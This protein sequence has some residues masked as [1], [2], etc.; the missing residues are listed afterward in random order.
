MIH[1]QLPASTYQ[2]FEAHDLPDA[3][4]I[5]LNRAL[6]DGT[7]DS[8]LQ[9]AACMIPDADPRPPR[10][11]SRTIVLEAERYGGAAIGVHGG[12]V[13]CGNRAGLSIKGIGCNPLVGSGAPED[14]AHGGLALSEGLREALWGEVFTIA[15]P[16]GAV[17][18]LGVIS[19]GSLCWWVEKR[20]GREALQDRYG[21]DV[22]I[23]RGLIARETAIRPAHFERAMFHCPLDPTAYGPT[24]DVTR[25]RDAAGALRDLLP[26]ADDARGPASIGDGLRETA[27]RFAAQSAA[28]KLNRFVHGNICSS[29]ICLD[30]R[31][32]D[33]GSV[34][35]IPDRGSLG[36]YGDYWRDH[37]LYD[38]IFALLSRAASKSGSTE[39]RL[40]CAE[41][42]SDIFS[43]TLESELEEG[44][45][46]MAGVPRMIVPEVVRDAAT[47]DLL[48]LMRQAANAGHPIPFDG[49]PTRESAF[50]ALRLNEVLNDV[51]RGS[52]PAS[53][54]APG[55]QALLTRLADCYRSFLPKL[56]AR[57]QFDDAA[58]SRF[59]DLRTGRLRGDPEQLYLPGTVSK[60]EALVSDYRDPKALQE[61][62]QAFMDETLDVAAYRYTADRNLNTTVGRIDG[63][64][65]LYDA[66][67]DT[68]QLSGHAPVPCTAERRAE[69]LSRLPRGTTRRCAVLR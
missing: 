18:A 56:Q 16:Y 45:M 49:H 51:A 17:R 31:W 14:Y 60:M 41:E 7:A 57:L 3:K 48:R 20:W 42:L 59:I 53:D 37:H 43:G 65:V 44:F 28:A 25:V 32:L 58:F 8:L 69:V 46:A 39:T 64:D 29:N 35:A 55:H 62:V 27:R 34:T 68:L 63:V 38:E 11:G 24:Q 67:T 13:R 52:A 5:H 33:F 66:K 10:F 4:L 61:A 6:Y 21:A 23:P 36:G 1:A 15:L 26:R 2:R 12:G 30:G 50:G 9:D 47:Q 22:Y 54:A 40:P 19:T